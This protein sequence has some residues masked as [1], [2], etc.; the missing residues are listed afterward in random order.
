M[1]IAI[2]TNR[3]TDLVRGDEYSVEVLQKAEQIF[4]PIIVLAELRAGFLCGSRTAEN[5]RTLVRFLNES[6]VQVLLP[7][8]NTSHH[9]ARLFLHLRNKGTPI[10]SNDI[11]IAALVAQHDLILFARDKHF[12]YLPQ[13]PLLP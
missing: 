7:D 9:Y 4:V 11:W 3:Y 1:R 8:E 12:A 10:P 2:D 5:E 6:G 13:I